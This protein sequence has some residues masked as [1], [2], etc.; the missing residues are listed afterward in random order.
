MPMRH[1]SVVKGYGGHREG[2]E[3]GNCGLIEKKESISLN[4][5]SYSY[6]RIIPKLQLNDR[7]EELST[8]KKKNISRKIARR[9]GIVENIFHSII[10]DRK[11]K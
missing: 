11:I 2:R 3:S 7:N 5:S 9:K 6:L 4:K 1:S 8:T 10:F